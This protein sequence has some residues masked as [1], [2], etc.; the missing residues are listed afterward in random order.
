MEGRD[1]EAALGE[2]KRASAAWKAWNAAKKH[3][4][5]GARRILAGA[6]HR[7]LVWPKEHSIAAPGREQPAPGA[8]TVHM[9][10]P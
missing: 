2:E 7:D 5:S 9:V 10:P 3:I 8:Q 4:E 6:G 1:G